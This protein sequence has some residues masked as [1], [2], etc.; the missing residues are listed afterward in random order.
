MLLHRILPRVSTASNS[1]A[2]KRVPRRL[3][4]CSHLRCSSQR[5]GGPYD[6]IPPP[7]SQLTTLSREYGPGVAQCVAMIALSTTKLERW[8]TVPRH[9]LPRTSLHERQSH[10]RTHCSFRWALTLFEPS[11]LA[12]EEWIECPLTALL[13]GLQTQ[14]L[15]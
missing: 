12:L 15:V 11:V 9:E 1:A 3:G 7:A 10:S 6:H 14:G 2:S 4:P 5:P 8:R 13:E